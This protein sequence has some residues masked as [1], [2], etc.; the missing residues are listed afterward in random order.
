MREGRKQ[1]SENVLLEYFR[2]EFGSN[3]LIC[4]LFFPY[5]MW[6][7]KKF[8]NNSLLIKIIHLDCSFFGFQL[9]CGHCASCPLVF[10]MVVRRCRKNWE[11]RNVRFFLL[12]L[13]T[14][15]AACGS[16]DGC[17]WYS[18]HEDQKVQHLIRHF[19]LQRPKPI[20]TYYKRREEVSEAENYDQ[21][22]DKKI[23]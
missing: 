10:Q 2:K 5:Y 14:A 16:A 1:R 11:D 12:S 17:G 20:Y 21:F 4:Q 13:K 8:N 23:F 22:A 3:P 9:K 18:S 15:A 19:L 6:I 7:G